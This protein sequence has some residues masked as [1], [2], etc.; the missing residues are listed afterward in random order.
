MVRP[1]FCG[2]VCSASDPAV[3]RV[4]HSLELSCVCRPWPRHCKLARGSVASWLPAWFG[5]KTTSEA[6]IA[7]VN[8]PTTQRI[9][10]DAT[11]LKELEN[12]RHANDR[13]ALGPGRQKTST[14]VL[15]SEMG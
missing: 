1:Y 7:L 5:A 10:K 2:L 13:H 6:S 11:H 8:E 4:T 9:G 14:P 12:H 3:G 15:A